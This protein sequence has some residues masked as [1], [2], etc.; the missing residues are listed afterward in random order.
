M[1]QGYDVLYFDLHGQP[2]A[3][4]WYGDDDLVA[5]TEAQI[6][7]ADLGGAVVFA[8]NC[9]LADDDSPMLDAL[10]NA[11][12][13]YVIG[14]PGLNFAGKRTIYGAAALGKSFIIALEHG[15]H[16]LKAL[17]IAKRSLSIWS[18][19]QAAPKKKAARDALQFKA[20]YRK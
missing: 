2:G 19:A 18:M 1:L 3:A 9:H 13:R 16:P 17:A 20:F 11:G 6:L 5:L 8:V 15:K 10:L 4:W 14:G 12:A 7:D